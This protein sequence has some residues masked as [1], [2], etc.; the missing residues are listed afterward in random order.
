MA[1]KVPEPRA[2]VDWD[3]LGFGLTT[4]ET[5]MLVAKCPG[6]GAWSDYTLVP[7]GPLPI[8]P[9]AT[10]LN[11]GQSIFE[12]MKAHRTAKGRIVVFR[13]E[14]NAYR[15]EDGAKRFVIQPI[16]GKL[17][18]EMVAAVVRA[19][20]DWVPPAGKGDLYLRPL[21]FGSGGALGVAPSPEF[22]M[23]IYVAPVGKYFASGARL[24]VES[25]HQRAAP[26]GVGST[27]AAGNYAPC[28]EAQ[29]AVKAKGFSDVIYLDA[30]A[31]ANLEEAASSN[32]F[33]LGKDGILRTPKLG[34]ILPGVTR[35]SILQ[36]A[37]HLANLKAH[38]G[39]K[40]VEE[41]GVTVEMALDATEV[42]LTGTGAGLSPVAHL[43]DDSRSVDL[44]L[45]GPVTTF[46]QEQLL[47]IRLEA[48]P[49]LFGW[50]WDV[51]EEDAEVRLK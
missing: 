24:K 48:A 47:A 44:Q 30:V 18:L 14:M 51:F 37:S 35:N 17:F 33:V 49:D 23:V 26:R 45:P 9:A 10:A 16:P 22:T 1:S 2:G 34:T 46:L 20:A 28:F 19:N 41:T 27:K 29:A 31:G 13:P 4:K 21:L 5:Q 6:D 3:N 40:G 8:E 39:L 36:L 25:G 15:L 50:L 38:E 43:A 12:G 11:Y 32:L 7:Y 42:V